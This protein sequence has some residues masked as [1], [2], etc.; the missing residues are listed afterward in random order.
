M[1]LFVALLS[2]LILAA[3]V[4]REPESLPGLEPLGYIQPRHARD[5]ASS[6]WGIQAG[7]L[8]ED[9]LER[10]AAIG[11]KWTRLGASWPS[12]EREKGVY[13]LLEATPLHIDDV[14]TRTGLPPSIVSATLL[15]L[16]EGVAVDAH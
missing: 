16:E 8:D 11:V 15:T 5:I 6:P 1:K 12:I 7:T 14:T 9:L 10:A 3:C 13:D 4:S 2:A